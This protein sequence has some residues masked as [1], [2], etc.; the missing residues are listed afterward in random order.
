MMRKQFMHK[1][2]FLKDLSKEELLEVLHK[3]ID[4]LCNCEEALSSISKIQ[5]VNIINVDREKDFIYVCVHAQGHEDGA[6]NDQWVLSEFEKHTGKNFPDG[7]DLWI[8][9]YTN[10]LTRPDRWKKRD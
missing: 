9:I 1:G 7:K 4:T 5:K 10:Y 8:T 6:F 2:K 3:T